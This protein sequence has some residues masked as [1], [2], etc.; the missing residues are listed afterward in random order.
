MKYITRK[1]SNGYYKL[2]KVNEQIFNTKEVF[3]GCLQS[4]KTKEDVLQYIRE[5]SNKKVLEQFEIR[6]HYENQVEH[7]T[8][9]QKFC[10]IW[11]NV[12]EKFHYEPI[13][14]GSKQK[15]EKYILNYYSEFL[16]IEIVE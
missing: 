1:D 8:A 13:Y 2:F 7:F 10:G 15:I 6:S 11:F 12:T 4:C 9:H 16:K 5:Y 14:Y 3:I